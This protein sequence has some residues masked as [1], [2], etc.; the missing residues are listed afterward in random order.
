MDDILDECNKAG[1]VQAY[2]RY[3]GLVC[4]MSLSRT[5]EPGKVADDS[6]KGVQ[7]VEQSC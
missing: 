3:K 2:V 5:I 7:H 6:K 1:S 4:D